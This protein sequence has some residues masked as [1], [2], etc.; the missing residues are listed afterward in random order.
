VTDDRP[1]DCYEILQVSSSAEHETIQR[2]FR[3]LAQR[4]HPDNKDTGDERRFREIQ[5]AYAVLTDPE[6][7]ARYDIGYE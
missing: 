5:E 3:M 1:F 7:R 4:Y 2:I 6:K